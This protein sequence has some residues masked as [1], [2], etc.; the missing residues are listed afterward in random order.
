MKKIE[1]KDINIKKEFVSDLCLLC[2]TPCC[3]E[4]F[5]PLIEEEIKSKKYEMIFE[6]IF[7]FE[8]KKVISGYFLKRKKD[9]SCIYLNEFDMCTIWKDRPL[10]CKIYICEKLKKS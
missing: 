7:S 3:K 9:G 5:V 10:S 4:N 1:N 6:T 8:D 2:D